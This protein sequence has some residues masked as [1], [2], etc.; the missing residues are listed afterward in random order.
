MTVEHPYCGTC[1]YWDETDQPIIGICR[2]N[3]PRPIR[4][5]EDDGCYEAWP[6][7]PT[8]LQSEWCGEH[9]RFV[10]YLDKLAREG[11]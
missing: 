6:L 8:T 7:W 2:K 5:L 4:L 10:G 11:P 3:A 1:P 9:P